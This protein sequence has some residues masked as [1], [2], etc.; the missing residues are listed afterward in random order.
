MS[1]GGGGMRERYAGV[2][3]GVVREVDDPERQG[4]I[5]VE[6]P[7][8]ADGQRSA[9]ASVAAAMAGGGRGA[10]F[11]PEPDDE[12][13]VAFQHGDFQHPYI[14]GFLW[15]GRDGAPA[16]DR[17]L[18]LLR[19]VNGHEVA[20]YDPEV[21]GGDQGHIRITAANGDEIRLGNQGISIR[22]RAAVV[23]D[24]PTV[25]INQRPVL[26]MAGRPI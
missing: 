13:L 26:P 21:T 2:V 20:L 12:A 22:S 11:M 25:A 14:V 8:M 18:R 24:A 9:W 17:R 10:F 4:R 16:P 23:I 6:F 15:N 19:S 5:R 3:I 1:S 7:W